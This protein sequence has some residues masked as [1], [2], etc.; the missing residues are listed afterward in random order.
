MKKQFWLLCLLGVILAAALPAQSNQPFYEMRIY[1]AEK[2]KLNALH[3]RFR[4]HTTALFEKHGMT[5]VGYWTP[6]DNPDEKLYYILSYPSQAAR[7]A[8]WAAFQADT[9]WQRVK[10]ASE[11]EG[12]LVAGVESIYLQTTP[13]SPNDFKPDCQRIWELRI[14][15]T[16][17]GRL[18]FL[19]RRFK[20]HT[21]KLFK[22]HGMRN[23]AYWS[24]VKA[25][26]GSENKLYYFLTHRSPAAAA[27]SFASFVNDPK[28]KKVAA[29]S[30]VA[31][32]GK[33]IEKIESIYLY[34][35]DYSP[36]R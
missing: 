21:M 9:T 1:T 29:D 19:N 20:D 23:I 7:D 12:K 13:Y 10:A 28:W 8:A 11:T 26:Q 36:V 22:K 24:P 27:A 4:N 33:I 14:Y 35:T 15:T 34:P 16:L 31:A 2:G 32:G 30:E 25:E 18:S 3:K 6:L 5:N 17:P